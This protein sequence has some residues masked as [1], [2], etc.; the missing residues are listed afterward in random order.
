[1]DPYAPQPVTTTTTE[2][3]MVWNDRAGGGIWWLVAAVGI[4]LLV[5]AAIIGFFDGNRT[6]TA[7]QVFGLLGF[8]CIEAGL[9]LS[10]LLG[11][12]W[13]WG[14]RVALMVAA[15]IIALRGGTVGLV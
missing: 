7:A 8:V 4:G 6:H 11:T 9:T 3:R 5:L 10:A 2:R 12:T 13:S 1:M 15:A 14:A